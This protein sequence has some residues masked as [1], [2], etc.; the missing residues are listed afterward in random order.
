MVIRRIRYRYHFLTEGKVRAHRERQQTFRPPKRA[1]GSFLMNSFRFPCLNVRM[2]WARAQ[3]V[4]ESRKMFVISFSARVHLYK[5]R[6]SIHFTRVT[7][8][9]RSTVS[10]RST[11]CSVVGCFFSLQPF[12]DFWSA[13]DP[14]DSSFKNSLL[15][16]SRVEISIIWRSVTV[17]LQHSIS[18]GIVRTTTSE[19]KFTG[20]TL[21]SWSSV[22]SWRKANKVSSQHVS[23]RWLTLIV[24]SNSHNMFA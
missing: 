2:V 23:I 16:D 12:V 18:L 21:F 7:N 20:G 4:V 15:S 3:H 5:T 24:H 14:K 19:W 17:Y 9:N 10:K 1:T 13:F 11:G 8:S 22:W 6:T